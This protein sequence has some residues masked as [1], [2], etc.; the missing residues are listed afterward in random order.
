MVKAWFE[1]NHIKFIRNESEKKNMEFA[2]Y[3]DVCIVIYILEKSINENVQLVDIRLSF[4]TI[5]YY[6]FNIYIFKKCGR[7]QLRRNYNAII[8]IEL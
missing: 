4:C 6:H 2:L 8:V 7:L 3:M 1:E 5:H